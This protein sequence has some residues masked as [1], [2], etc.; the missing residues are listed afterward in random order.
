M[1][2]HIFD[3]FVEKDCDMIEI[4]PLVV[5]KNGT[6]MAADSKIVIDSNAEFR[7]PELFA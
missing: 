3:C 5:L 6:V 2:K 4:N 1:F 7:Q